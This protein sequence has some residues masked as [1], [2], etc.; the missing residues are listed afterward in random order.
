M[1]ATRPS[2]VT[3]KVLP[4]V[5]RDVNSQLPTESHVP[6]LTWKFDEKL[7][8]LREY[9]RLYPTGVSL[10]R[11]RWVAMIMVVALAAAAMGSVTSVTL[12]VSA[13][14]LFLLGGGCAVWLIYR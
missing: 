8:L 9:R 14:S 2:D 5:I 4:V 1:F 13:A 11:L 10:H 7:R 3:Y 12:S 6:V